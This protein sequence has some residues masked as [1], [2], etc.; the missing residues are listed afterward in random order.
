MKTKDSFTLKDGIDGEELKG[1]GFPESMDGEQGEEAA[2][3]LRKKKID[4]S[5]DAL[6]KRS[7]RFSF[8]YHLDTVG[9]N[10]TR[11]SIMRGFSGSDC[12]GWRMEARY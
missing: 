9:R 12:L 2:S 6:D 3:I 11:E 4:G 7:K 1:W 5:V 10:I 8:S